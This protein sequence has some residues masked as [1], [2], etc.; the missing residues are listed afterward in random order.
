MVFSKEDQR[1]TPDFITPDLW[2]ITVPTLILWITGYGE[3][4]RD[5]FIGSLL[6]TCMDELKLRLIEALVRHPAKRH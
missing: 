5:V 1:E 2:P 3:Y 6:R 4:C